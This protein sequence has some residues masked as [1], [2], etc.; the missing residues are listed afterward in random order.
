MKSMPLGTPLAMILTIAW[1][2]T[3]APVFAATYD[4]PPAEENV[5]GESLHVLA[6]QEDTL[7]TIARLYGLGYR[8]IR[9]AN[10]SVNPWLPGENTRVLVP[11][12]FIL[13]D[14]PRKGIV[15]NI[16]EMR[17]Y[18]FPKPAAGGKRKVLTY[19]ISIGRGDWQTPLGV[20]H[21]T[22][23][24]KDPAW[25]P[26]ESILKEHQERG[27]TL[28]KVVPHGPDNPLGDFA[29]KLGLPG[30]L[31]HGTNKSSGIGMQVTH[32]CIRLYPRDIATLYR[33][34]PVGTPVRI[35]NQPIKAGWLNGTLYLEIHPT[36]EQDQ[37]I[38]AYR[39]LTPVVRQIVFATKDKPDY[40]I[41][42]N[43]VNDIATHPRGVVLPVN[44]GNGFFDTSGNPPHHIAMK[45]KHV[46]H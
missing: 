25:Y 21:V 14:A 31:I 1:F 46:E 22:R 7:L 37:D 5:I 9:L 20:T 27:D 12:R 2:N 4:L 45:G 34:V 33:K 39:D 32:G 44:I 28:E 38:N 43:R 35:I 3:L 23:K 24:I 40:S 18:Y 41:D 10:P 13:P 6:N 26:P 19:P 17:L 8:E 36:V 15:I 11:S 16:A 30:Y 29:L 42:W